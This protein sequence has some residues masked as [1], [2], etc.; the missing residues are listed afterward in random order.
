[1]TGRRWRWVRD[2]FFGNHRHHR[3]PR[4]RIGPP[5]PQPRI[6]QQAAQQNRTKVGAEI[7][8]LGIGVHGS[9][10]DSGSNSPLRSYHK[11]QDG[12]GAPK[13]VRPSFDRISSPDSRRPSRP[14]EH[15]NDPRGVPAQLATFQVD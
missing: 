14:R 7:G 12:G 9:T 15:S 6:Q 4:H 8:L 2:A 10:S 11:R 5:P 3:Q 1:M 13:P